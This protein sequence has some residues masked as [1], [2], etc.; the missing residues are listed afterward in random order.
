MGKKQV[1]LL[2]ILTVLT[3]LAG[4]YVMGGTQAYGRYQQ[5]NLA[6]QEHC[7]GQ[8]PVRICVRTPAT[9]FS[10]F[11]PSYL[12]SQYPL[13]AVDY[14]SSSPLTLV[15]SVS[16]ARFSQVQ[17][18][19]VNATSNQQTSN[20]IPPMQGQVLQKLTTEQN[21]SLLVRVTDTQNHL[22]YDE[23]IPLLLHSRWLMEWLTS[24]RLKI[25]AWVTPDDPAIANLV[26]K[27]ATHLHDQ[28][29]PVPSGMIGYKTATPQQVIDQVDAIYDTLRL[30]YHIQYVQA[31]VPYSSSNSN[32]SQATENI[33]LPAEVLAQHSGMCV[34]LTA[35]LAAAAERIG[36][37]TSIVI[38]PGHA[39][40]GVAVTE[41]GKR[42]E[43]WDAVDMN[44]NVAADSSNVQADGVYMKNLG[45]HTIV[46]TILL[47]EARNAHVG[48]ML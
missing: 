11:Y 4:A 1:M 6:N 23:D 30:D 5:N 17:T 9:I 14:S 38:I 35:L 22:Y 45:Q 37:H 27:A 2:L 48:P 20:F 34:E 33:K 28:Q 8:A 12:G 46:D 47:S 32:D 44:N 42:F 3:V 15:I 39:F 10:A 26:T 36:L 24:N 41:D 19:T 31:S 21:T 40:L 29:P 13:F 43:Y 7:G 18:Q 25:A 16:I